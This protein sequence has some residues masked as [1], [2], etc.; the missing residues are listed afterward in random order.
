MFRVEGVYFSASPK[1]PITNEYNIIDAFSKIIGVRPSFM[2][3]RESLT[4]RC[5]ISVDAVVRV[6]TPPHIQLMEST[7]ISSSER[8]T[9][10]NNQL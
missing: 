6:L 7:T 2:R 1:C 9:F 10:V 8:R 5:C 4:L 3:P